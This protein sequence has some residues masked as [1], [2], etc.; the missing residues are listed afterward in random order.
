MPECA[1]LELETVIFYCFTLLIKL[2]VANDVFLQLL[3]DLWGN[4]Y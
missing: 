3:N 4:I 2:A 1:G